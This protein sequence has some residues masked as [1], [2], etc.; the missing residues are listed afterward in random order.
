MLHR[1]WCFRCSEQEST[2]GEYPRNQE[3]VP[4]SAGNIPTEAVASTMVS[5]GSFAES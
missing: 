3:L 1:H 2:Q 4:W 5:R